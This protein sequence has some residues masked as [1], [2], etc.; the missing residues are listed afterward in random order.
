MH[1]GENFLGQRRTCGRKTKC[2]PGVS[3]YGELF[4]DLPSGATMTFHDTKRGL[5]GVES[6]SARGNR[7]QLYPERFGKTRMQG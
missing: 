5:D 3:R 4:G 7:K 6:R 2:A 1:Y